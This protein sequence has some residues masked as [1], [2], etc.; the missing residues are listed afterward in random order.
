MRLSGREFRLAKRCERESRGSIFIMY[1]FN[2]YQGILCTRIKNKK[3]HAWIFAPEQN[4]RGI[5]RI[6]Y[7]GTFESS[8]ARDIKFYLLHRIFNFYVEFML[9][10][11]RRPRST[12][13]VYYLKKQKAMH[14]DIYRWERKGCGG[15]PYAV[16][17]N[18]IQ[19][20]IQ[21]AF[22]QEEKFPRATPHTRR[23]LIN[24]SE[25]SFI[26]LIQKLGA[27][28]ES[29]R[30]GG[31]SHFTA[32]YFYAPDSYGIIPGHR[33]YTRIRLEPVRA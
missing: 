31:G 22:S 7:I 30:E 4:R 18:F 2:L 16:R 8:V 25:L 23:M 28:G 20:E 1:V 6:L 33:V 5:S 10:H 29:E 3:A 11:R 19:L 21:R 27:G 15:S 9:N 13:R 26:Y 14:E 32:L 17:E 12:G 24:R